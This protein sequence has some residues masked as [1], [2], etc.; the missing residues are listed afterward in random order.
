MRN[1]MSVEEVYEKLDRLE[2]L[3]KEYDGLATDCMKLIGLHDEL[4]DRLGKALYHFDHLA[5]IYNLVKDC[6]DATEV[7][8]SE[9]EGKI[10]GLMEAKRYIID[11]LKDCLG[12]EETAEAAENEEEES[13]GVC[14]E[15]QV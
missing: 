10:S 1:G 4:I 5:A 3:E 7:D 15:N 12:S 8:K 6:P 11:I 9:F 2:E 13:D 14:P